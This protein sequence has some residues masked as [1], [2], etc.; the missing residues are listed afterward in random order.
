MK[1]SFVD[2][3]KIK[4]NNNMHDL[5]TQYQEGVIETKQSSVFL[6]TLLKKNQFIKFLV[7]S[8]VIIGFQEDHLEKESEHILN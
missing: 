7:N 1:K 5:S 2:Q 4:L 6:I 3:I 8:K